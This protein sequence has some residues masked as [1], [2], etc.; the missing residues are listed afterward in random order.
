[1]DYCNNYDH[2]T[3]TVE[4]PSKPVLCF[5]ASSSAADLVAEVVLGA[6]V[7]VAPLQ[8]GVSTDEV[9]CVA[10]AAA[11]AEGLARVAGGVPVP[12][13]L[14]PVAGAAVRPQRA[15]GR[16]WREQRRAATRNEV[17]VGPAAG[18]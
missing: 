1:M 3:S 12:A 16:V 2:P 7:G 4:T 6:A 14:K 17:I 11:V 13:G 5:G 8:A 15:G 10:A 9:V 18:L